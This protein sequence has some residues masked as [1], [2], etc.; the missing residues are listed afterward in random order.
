[1]AGEMVMAG[2]VA[3]AVVGAV[4]VTG[5]DATS[6]AVFFSAGSEAIERTR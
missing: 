2:A 1:M 6:P 5:R 3:D 4:V